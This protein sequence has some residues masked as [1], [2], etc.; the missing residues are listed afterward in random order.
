VFDSPFSRARGL[1]KRASDIVLSLV[2]LA[3]AAPLVLP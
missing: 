1:I 3:L 2:I